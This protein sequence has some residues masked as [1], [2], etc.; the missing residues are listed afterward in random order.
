M[1][2]R[3]S[4]DLGVDSPRIVNLRCPIC[5]HLGA[6]HGLLNILDLKWIAHS[7]TGRGV[8]SFNAGLRLCPNNDCRALV[9]VIL[10]SA[11]LQQ[12]YPPEVIDF[13]STNLPQ[14]ILQSLEEAIKCHAAGCNKASALMV[15]RVLEEL[16]QAKNAQGADLKKRLAALGKTIVMP[17]ELLDAADQLRILG[18]D[19]AHVE[20]K[21]YDKIG[22]DEAELAIE[23][24]KELLK[25]AYQYT[26]LVDRLKELAKPATP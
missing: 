24:T 4:K 18:N 26:A 3:L 11:E 2:I 12:A 5:G 19:A 23:L 14:P 13:D 17:Q 21:V 20:A 9:F 7:A 16:C 22:P 6:F 8:T 1:D 10:K 15:R 25:A